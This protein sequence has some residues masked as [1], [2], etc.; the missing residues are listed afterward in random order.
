MLVRRSSSAITSIHS[1]RSCLPPKKSARRSE[2]VGRCQ[3]AAASL[4]MSAKPR[5]PPPNYMESAQL[6]RRLANS[7]AG[8]VRGHGCLWL[9]HLPKFAVRDNDSRGS[10][11]R[12][13]G[14]EALSIFLIC[15]S[16]Q[17]THRYCHFSRY[18]NLASE[19]VARTGRPPT[20]Q[21]CAAVSCKKQ[22]LFNGAMDAPDDVGYFARKH[23][24]STDQAWGLMRQLGRDRNKFNEAAAKLS[25]TEPTG[26]LLRSF[27]GPQLLR[28]ILPTS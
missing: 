14:T 13:I 6:K 9:C 23:D 21:P 22:E 5:T 26:G 17:V 20:S 11:L 24:I 3:L 27:V 25:Q 15:N 19:T 16:F 18:A 7:P 2:E 12:A 1:A 8:A 10:K 28:T 4:R